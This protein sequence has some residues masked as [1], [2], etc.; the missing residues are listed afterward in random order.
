MKGLKLALL[1]AELH[2]VNPEHSAKPICSITEV[3]RKFS[4][5]LRKIKEYFGEFSFYEDCYKL[6]IQMFKNFSFDELCKIRY[7]TIFTMHETATD[8]FERN[9]KYFVVEKIRSS[10]WR[11]GS[12][13][14]VWNEV[15]DA[16]NCIRNFHFSDNSDFEVTLDHSTYHNEKGYS[17]YSRTFLDGSFG[18]LVHYKKQHVMTIGF[19]VIKGKGILVQQVQL[20][21]RSKNRFLYKLPSNRLEYVIGLFKTAFPDHYLYVADGGDVAER[22]LEGYKIALNYAEDRCE[23]YKTDIKHSKDTESIERYTE[24][25][26]ESQG[27]LAELSNKIA[28]LK[29]D[30]KRLVEFYGN[31]GSYK[32]YRENNLKL[33]GIRHYR[34]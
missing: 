23:R 14:D 12:G 6:P 1:R 32:I 27:E 25:L 24:W 3:D 10:M 19:S 13:S 11:W 28:H 4:G 21:Q 30:K 2:K 34:V 22:N 5:K 7:S 33:N 16:Y 26:I 8:L 18:Y 20:V 9:Y 29:A 15:V 31:V 17:R